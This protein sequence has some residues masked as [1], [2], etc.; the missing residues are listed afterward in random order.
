MFVIASIEEE[1]LPSL[2]VDA[3]ACRRVSDSR[4]E[5]EVGNFT[6]RSLFLRS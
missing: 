6:F 4:I 2:D 5:R 1:L 3:L